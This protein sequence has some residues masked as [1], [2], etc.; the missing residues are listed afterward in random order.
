M[1]YTALGILHLTSAIL[2]VGSVFMGSFID[3]PVIRSATPKGRFPFDFIVGQGHRVFAAVYV[4]VVS[5]LVS[6]IGMVVLRPPQTPQQTVMLGFKGVALTFMVGSTIYGSLSTWPKIQ[7][8]TNG[9]AFGYYKMYMR[10]AYAVVV[11]G[12]MSSVIGYLYAARLL[13]P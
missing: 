12:L 4:G 10:R 2:W 9:E 7:F 1:L 13:A 6:S 11:L 8:A 5:Q 3:W